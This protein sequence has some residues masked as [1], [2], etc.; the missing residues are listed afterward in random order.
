M[1]LLLIF[2]SVFLHIFLHIVFLL[3]INYPCTNCLKICICLSA[4][5]FSSALYPFSFYLFIDC[6]S[7]CNLSLM[8]CLFHLSSCLLFFQVQICM[9]SL[10]ELLSVFI[11]SLNIFS[12]KLLICYL[13]LSSCFIFSSA[14]M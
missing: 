8:Y 1:L 11:L 12:F 9:L 2:C 13:H 10:L 14:Y 7:A 4:S 5:F 3:F 6:P